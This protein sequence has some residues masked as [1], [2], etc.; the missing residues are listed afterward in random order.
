[1]RVIIKAI[2]LQQCFL[3][4]HEFYNFPA[5]CELTAGRLTW[6]PLAHTDVRSYDAVDVERP[7]QRNSPAV[8]SGCTLEAERS[9]REQR[10]A[11]EEE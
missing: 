11:E 3:V 1:M 6:C 10:E 9:S 2:S 8:G 5:L 4:F 7:K